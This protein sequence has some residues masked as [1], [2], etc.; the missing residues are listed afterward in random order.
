MT[1]KVS[2]KLLDAASSTLSIRYGSP[3]SYDVELYAQFV[4]H[5]ADVEAVWLQMIR[6]QTAIKKGKS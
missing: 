2:I 3:G 4:Q 6:R 5:L 1:D